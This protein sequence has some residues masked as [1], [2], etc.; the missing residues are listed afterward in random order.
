MKINKNKEIK[1][2]LKIILI[3]F[4][5]SFTVIIF[6]I[7]LHEAGHWIMSEIDPY[8]EPVEY[9]I[10]HVNEKNNKTYTLNSL[11]GYVTVTEKYPGALKERPIWADF[12]QE[13]ICIS[14]Q[15]IISFFI[16][17]KTIILIE[18]KHSKTKKKSSFKN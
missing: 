5:I 14:I 10:F 3:G 2:I 4:F 13:I 18:K 9:H 12:L 17:I 1:K 6:S 8:I 7:P 11:L 15:I 16:T